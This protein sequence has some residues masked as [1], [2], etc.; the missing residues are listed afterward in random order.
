[1][2]AVLRHQEAALAR[3]WRVTEERSPLR[4]VSAPAERYAW[5]S[6]VFA[7]DDGWTIQVYSDAGVWDYLEELI[8]PDGAVVRPFSDRADYPADHPMEQLRS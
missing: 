6:V 2:R 5:G 4:L 3:L 8:D 1:M 7:T